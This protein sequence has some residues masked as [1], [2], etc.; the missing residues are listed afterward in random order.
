MGLARVLVCIWISLSWMAANVEAQGSVE[1]S[2]PEETIETSLPSLSLPPSSLPTML[3]AL[4][5]S[6]G[7]SPFAKE[8]VGADAVPISFGAGAFPY[9]I[10]PISA[11]ISA[12]VVMAVQSLREQGKINPAMI[13]AL[14]NNS[15]Y[16]AGV[17][18]AFSGAVAQKGLKVSTNYLAGRF[19][20]KMIESIAKNRAAI[21][22]TNI[23]SG[24]TFTLSVGSGFEYFSQFWKLACHGVEGVSTVSGFLNA[25][26]ESRLAVINNLYKYIF[27]KDVQKRIMN[28]VLYNRILTFEFIAMNVAMYLG[29]VTGGL[30]AERALGKLAPGAARAWSRVLTD[31]FAKVFGGVVFGVAIQFIPDGFRLGVNRELVS[32]KLGRAK[33]SLHEKLALIEEG[34]RRRRYPF[35]IVSRDAGGDSSSDPLVR[36]FASLFR[37]RD[38]I[39]SMEIQRL[40]I[41]NE[42]KSAEEEMRS[43]QELVESK[44]QL[45]E[46][47]S[48]GLSGLDTVEGAEALLSGKSHDALGR[49]LHRDLFRDQ[50]Q[51]HYAGIIAAAHRKTKE[52]EESFYEFFKLVDEV[53]LL[54]AR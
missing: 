14:L 26:V 10:D 29:A 50:Y 33:S 39:I 35:A 22:F 40:M 9:Q 30:I 17:V 21:Y 38:L 4:G 12:A 34:I 43:I 53:E 45:F 25:P 20:P 15:D 31:Y 54:P 41:L 19:A 2:S 11:F 28:S 51:K 18:G 44:M 3:P 7:R 36:D 48:G 1:I 23:V 46:K 42:P 8:V 49:Q 13:A 52:H 16:Y 47:M 37:T 24:I 27:M 32:W 5:T 6:S